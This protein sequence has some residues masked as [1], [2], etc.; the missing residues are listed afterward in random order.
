MIMPNSL[1]EQLEQDFQRKW[2]DFNQVLEKEKLKLTDDRK[3]LETLQRVFIFSDFIASGCIRN[4]GMLIDLFKT[5]DLSNTYHQDSYSQSIKKLLTDAAKEDQLEKI[6]RGLKLREMVRIAWRDISGQAGLEETMADITAFADACIDASLSFLYR[7]HCLANGVPHGISG[8]QQLVVI[9]LG[10][11]GGSE[12]NFSSDVDL[13]FLYPEDGETRGVSRPI[14]NETF[15][16]SLCRKLIK[17]LGRVTKEGFVFR[18]DTRLRPYGENGP[19]AVSFDMLEQ[20]CQLQGRDWERYAWI[21]ARCVAGDRTEGERLLQKLKPFVYRRYLDYNAFESMRSMKQKIN[22]ELNRKGMKENIKLGPGGIR[23]IEFFGQ[24]F[25]L[26]RGGVVPTLQDQGIR[27]I[28]SALSGEGYVSADVCELLDK[29]YIFLRSTENRLQEYADRQTHTLPVE[30]VER[31]RLALSLNFTGEKEFNECLEEHRENVA[32]HFALLLEAS[33]TVGKNRKNELEAIW[34]GLVEEDLAFSFLSGMGYN[35]PD[36]ILK[37]LKHLRNDPAIQTLGLHGRQRLDKLIPLILAA[38]S[39]SETPEI[40]LTRIFMLVKAIKRRTTYLALLLENPPSLTHLVRLEEASPFIASFLANHPVLLD[41]LLDP[42]VLYA[43]PK[44]EEIDEELSRRIERVSHDFEYQMEELCIIRQTNMLRVCAADVTEILPLMKVSDHLTEIAEA[45]VN[46]VLRLSWNY[47]E[48]KHGRPVCVLDNQ[49]CDEGFA[50]IAYGKMGGYELGYDSDLDL[51]F[52]HAGTNGQTR[53]SSRPIDNSQFFARLGQ[54]VLHMLTMHTRAGI[55]YETDTRLRPSGSSGVLVSHIE[56]F[57]EY[58]VKD[59]W[60]WEHQALIK[61]RAI[62]GDERLKKHFEKIRRSVLSVCRKKNQLRKDVS[63]MRE[64]MRRELL[65]HQSGTFDL[66]QSPGGIV[67][68]EFIV[69]YFVLLKARQFPELLNWTDVVRLLYT[70]Y[71]TG[72]VD[73]YTVNILRYAY[74]VY[75]AV[76]HKLSLQERPPVVRDERFVRLRK[77]VI[78]IWQ[79]FLE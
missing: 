5:G 26:I 31:Y 37:L 24:I 62:G 66:K 1:S 56:S 52:L 3:F 50:V 41:E 45:V 13:I 19:L 73:E 32:K 78:L 12:L 55:L 76:A 35:R 51:V 8:P 38:V 27:K 74:L 33:D 11:L 21:K 75:R 20:Y 30:P 2:S 46:K 43:P 18:V 68:I 39:N 25:Q 4:P 9:G 34:H 63:G 28:L 6:L 72:G 59:A 7:Q 67:D 58:Q 79:K 64:R 17:V 54:R 29:A 10:K 14:A 15:F 70:L 40:T 22:L 65:N 71:K 16:S 53:D 61:A 44:R 42:R 77:S 69:Q 60:T 23:E 57:M 49:E 48:K 47:L 36:E